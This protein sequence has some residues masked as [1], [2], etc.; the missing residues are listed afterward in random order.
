MQRLLS[1]HLTGS[2]SFHLDITKYVVD[3]KVAFVADSS[4]LLLLFY[5][6]RDSMTVCLWSLNTQLLALGTLK[7]N[8]HI[9]NHRTR[10]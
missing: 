2:T 7:G 9:Y 3:C 10:R 8:L 5:R 1:I 6:T 4:E